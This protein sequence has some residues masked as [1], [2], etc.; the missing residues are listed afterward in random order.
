MSQPGGAA[1]KKR[2]VNREQR[3][4]PLYLWYHTIYIH[5]Q[6]PHN[7]PGVPIYFSSYGYGVIRLELMPMR[8]STTLIFLMAGSGGVVEQVSSEPACPPAY[9]RQVPW[10]K[11]DQT[12]RMF[13]TM[14]PIR[15]GPPQ[16]STNPRPMVSHDAPCT[17][18][19]ED[20]PYHC[21]CCSNR[22]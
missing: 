14:L 17:S 7:S 19:L 4:L 22:T 3:V 18:D 5:S 6:S 11:C 13:V 12:F 16:T 20:R 8:N 21:H 2:G 1:P 9:A 10:T 15:S